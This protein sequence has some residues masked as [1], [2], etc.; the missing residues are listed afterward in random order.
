MD[1]STD[2]SPAAIRDLTP[3]QT[4]SRR[5]RCGAEIKAVVIQTAAQYEM[6]IEREKK[7][8][9]SVAV[10]LKSKRRRQTGDCSNFLASGV[11]R[12]QLTEI[13]HEVIYGATELVGME[14]TGEMEIEMARKIFAR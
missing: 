14:I 3:L 7:R 5:Q 2:E 10:A 13:G 1:E 6:H 11:H 9:R 12:V 4:R 8:Q